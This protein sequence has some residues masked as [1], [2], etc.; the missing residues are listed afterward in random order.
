MGPAALLDLAQGT[1]AHPASDPVPPDQYDVECASLSDR[2]FESK[3]TVHTHSIYNIHFHRFM[4]LIISLYPA[5]LCAGQHHTCYPSLS[6]LHR[7]GFPRCSVGRLLVC[8]SPASLYLLPAASKGWENPKESNLQMLPW[9]PLLPPGLLQHLWGAETADWQAD[10]ACWGDQVVW[11]LPN[12]LP[13]SGS[14][15]LHGG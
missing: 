13:V 2:D 8:P 14:S 11:A 10:G 3:G 5:L 15:C 12:S 6:L 1:Y 7:Q 9:W 4:Y